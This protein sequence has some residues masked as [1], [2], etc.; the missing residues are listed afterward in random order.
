MRVIVVVAGGVAPAFDVIV[1]FFGLL[2]FA[3]GEVAL[4]LLGDNIGYISFFGLEVVAHGF[5]LVGCAPLVEYRSA[6]EVAH[7][8]FAATGIN[9]AC[10]EVELNLF[11]IK[12]QVVVVN[13]PFAIHVGGLFPDQDHRVFRR[14]CDL[15]VEV[16]FLPSDA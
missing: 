9:F 3:A 8:V 11:C 14:E 4:P 12:F 7:A 5:R 16:D 13:F 1:A 15:G 2:C 6:Y 10:V